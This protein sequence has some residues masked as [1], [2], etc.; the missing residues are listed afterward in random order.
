MQQQQTVP[1]L[2]G[3]VDGLTKLVENNERKSKMEH[4]CPDAL[5]TFP[6]LSLLLLKAGFPTKSINRV[7]I[8]TQ[9]VD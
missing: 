4:H 1:A 9:P 2:I 8:S 6:S 7:G 5:T 3:K